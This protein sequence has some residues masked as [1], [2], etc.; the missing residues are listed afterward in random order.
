MA[1][2]YG[3]AGIRT[4]A[5]CPGAIVSGLT[6][7]SMVDDETSPYREA[8]LNSPAGRIGEPEDIA[9]AALYLA[10]DEST[11]TFGQHLV[12]DGGWTL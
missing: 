4:N 10:S 9:Y 8:I 1:A 11:F 12:I 6:P 7:R 2:A 5:I 3:N